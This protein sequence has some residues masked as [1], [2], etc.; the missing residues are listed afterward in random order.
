MAVLPSFVKV[1]EEKELGREELR[2]GSVVEAGVVGSVS[3]AFAD[4]VYGEGDDVK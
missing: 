2:L 3:L 4:S 1:V